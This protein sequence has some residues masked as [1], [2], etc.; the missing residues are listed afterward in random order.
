MYKV[1]LIQNQS[2]MSHNRFADMRDFLERKKIQYDLFTGEN[3]DLISSSLNGSNYDAIIFGTNSLNDRVVLEAVTTDKFK[4]AL[5]EHLSSNKGILIL[6]QLNYAKNNDYL[7]FLPI[8]KE[9][10]SLVVGTSNNSSRIKFS[11]FERK[12]LILNYPHKIQEGMVQ[13]RALNSKNIAGLYWHSIEAD[14]T[15]WEPV[16]ED[17]N[18]TLFSV[19][20]S[21]KVI[22]TS[23]LLDWQEH[24]ELLFNTLGYLMRKSL[25]IAFVCNEDTSNDTR[26]YILKYFN[27]RQIEVVNYYLSKDID[28]LKSNL[29]QQLHQV[30]LFNEGFDVNQ[31]YE[32]NS[33]IKTLISDNDVRSIVL[34]YDKGSFLLYGTANSL[35]DIGLS[36]ELYIKNELATGYVEG[37]FWKTIE[38]L[39]SLRVLNPQF[40]GEYKDNLDSINDRIANSIVEGTYDKTFQATCA[41]LWYR[42]SVRGIKN[43]SKTQKWLNTKVSGLSAH[44]YLFLAYYKNKARISDVDLEVLEEKFIEVINNNPKELDL[45]I[46]LH[47]AYHYKLK[48]D[49]LDKVLDLI[50]QTYYRNGQLNIYNKA[51][52]SFVLIELFNEKRLN[53][54]MKSILFDTIIEL[55]KYIINAEIKKGRFEIVSLI[56]AIEACSKFEKELKFP[57]TEL[58][59]LVHPKNELEVVSKV[60]LM[61]A[62]EMR[63]KYYNMFRENETNKRKLKKLRY[64]NYLLIS[65]IY[66]SFSLIYGAF[67]LLIYFNDE[68]RFNSLLESIK[69]TW[70]YHTAILSVCM[71]V[72][73][74]LINAIGKSYAKEDK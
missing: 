58:F 36:L 8:D 55:R 2:E 12:K 24:E 22:V 56:K 19:Y 20:K 21:S 47:I 51:N 61:N 45:T 27:I 70:P 42:R 26:E 28:K 3:I 71:F 37:S 15:Y 33:E 49:Y 13:E 18:K 73:A 11:T 1:C 35:Y 69:V 57:T 65:L 40:D 74:F 32:T 72:I 53:E 64:H 31:L 9:S 39:Q 17:E 66:I 63:I 41:L 67:S 44:D 54:N 62:E 14:K 50:E 43:T 68:Q 23:L 34:N 7:D 16:I 25:P 4:M 46:L 10:I 59:K 38:V 52:I 5:D 6:S 60:D 29:Q 48:K 30:I